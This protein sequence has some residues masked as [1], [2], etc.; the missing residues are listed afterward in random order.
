MTQGWFKNVLMGTVFLT[1][2]VE[3]QESMND[4][5]F[6]LPYWISRYEYSLPFTFKKAPATKNLKENSVQYPYNYYPEKKKKRILKLISSRG[7]YL[8]LTPTNSQGNLQHLKQQTDLGSKRVKKF[9]CQQGYMDVKLSRL[10][11]ETLTQQ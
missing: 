10:K 2:L 1:N 9:T 4:M 7:P 11:V 5:T 6:C 3:Q 8:D